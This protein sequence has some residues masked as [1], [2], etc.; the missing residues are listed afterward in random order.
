LDRRTGLKL[1]AIDAVFI[2]HEHGDHH[3]G[4]H[5]FPRAQW[6]AAPAVAEVMNA[7]GQYARS[8]APIETR[9]FGDVEVLATPGHTLAHHSLRFLWEGKVVVV[10]GDAVMTRDF[11][12]DRQGFF[13]S[14]NME[15]A[16]R[17]IARL[18]ETTDIVVPGHDNYFLAGRRG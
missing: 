12:R 1:D 9:L 6:L 4:L 11:W 17:T 18:A 2:T 10:A 5:C 16:G 13:N 14:V 8:I 7:A 3:Y 15:L